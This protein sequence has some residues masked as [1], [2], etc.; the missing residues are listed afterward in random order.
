MFLIIAPSVTLVG[1]F[2]HSLNFLFFSYFQSI[3]TCLDA[4][5]LN[6]QALCNLTPVEKDRSDRIFTLKEKHGIDSGSSRNHP[7]AGLHR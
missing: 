2:V 4:Q 3:D 5:K 1:F 7:F 6:T